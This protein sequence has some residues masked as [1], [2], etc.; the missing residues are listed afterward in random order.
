MK[1][2]CLEL[3]VHGADSIFL[4]FIKT[5]TEL[6]LVDAGYPDMMA[7]IELKLSEKGCNVADVTQI[8]IT[9]H[10]H[11]HVG[12]LAELKEKNQGIT[13]KANKPEI[14]FIQGECIS[15]RLE[16]AI[17]QQTLLPE[18]EQ[19][20]GRRFQAYLKSIAPCC[21]DEVL[22]PGEF[23]LNDQIKVLNTW[24]HTQGHIS[25]YDPVSRTLLAGDLMVLDEGELKLPFPQYS[26]D[27]Q[28]AKASIMET[29]ELPIR[30]IICYHGGM[31][32][33]NENE[34][35]AKMQK[36]ASNF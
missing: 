17:G 22:I 29:A 9:H 2:D 18:N 8:W 34:L 11:D 5:D 32:I 15:L 3:A 24:G 28:K 25:F 4:P 6:I 1:I 16:Q 14:A 19:E 33:G 10:D 20:N 36:A 30:C 21:V 26:Y 13:V 12:S 7:E 31:I 35:K 27:L 23:I